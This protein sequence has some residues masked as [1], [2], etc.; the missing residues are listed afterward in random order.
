MCLVK[1]GKNALFMFQHDTFP[2]RQKSARL[3]EALHLGEGLFSYVNPRP[4]SDP[5]LLH[6]GKGML[7]LSE[8]VFLVGFAL[9]SSLLVLFSIF[10]KPK[11]ML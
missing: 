7:C 5:C 10:I 11:R 1:K 4:S 8:P 2:P 9:T 6:L 3:G